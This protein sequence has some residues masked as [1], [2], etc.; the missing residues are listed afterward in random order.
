MEK[1]GLPP[2]PVT[3]G[4]VLETFAL[5]EEIECKFLLKCNGLGCIVGCLRFTSTFQ[6]GE[7]LRND[8]EVNG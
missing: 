6:T 8:R 1:I 7:T 5:C 4:S 2:T 3:L